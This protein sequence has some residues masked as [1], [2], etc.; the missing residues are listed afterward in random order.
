[1]AKFQTMAEKPHRSP[2]IFYPILL[3][4][5]PVLLLLANNLDQVRLNAGL[6]AGLYSLAG[7]VAL[8]LLLRLVLKDWGK[9]A[10]VSSW[11]LLLFFSY[12]HIYGLV[13]DKSLAGFIYGRHR[14][15]GPLWLALLLAGSWLLV[16]KTRLAPGLHR[17]L[18]ITILVLVLFP[19]FIIGYHEVRAWRMSNQPV[20]KA[21]AD[22]GNSGQDQA[23]QPDIYWIIL[24]GYT[25]SDVLSQVYHY[26]N[27]PF[28]DQLKGMGFVIPTCSQSNYAWTALSLSSAL[29]MNYLETYN[30]HMQA[31]D[32]RPDY[33]A[34]QGFIM[35]NPVRDKLA[36][37]GYKMIAFETD[38]PFTEVTDADIYIVGNA[39]PLE[40]MKSGFEIS[41]FEEMFMRTT[42]MRILGEAQGAFLKKVVSQV[43]TP[44][45]VH[46]DRIRFVLD[47][48]EAIPGLVPGHKFVFAH[49]VA[50]H[51]PYV[52]KPDGQYSD[53]GSPEIGYPDEIAYLDMRMIEIV[54]TILA[55]SKTPPVIIIQGDHGW[56]DKNRMANLNAYYLPNGGSQKIYPTIT[57]VNSFRIILDQYFGGNYNLL[58][59]R[60]YYSSETRQFDF[61]LVPSNCAVN[62]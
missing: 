2:I 48:L 47:Q 14:F 25:R 52:F 42:A 54:K 7:G 57:P 35:H 49:M 62:Q 28:L 31:P 44:N 20:V 33:L 17:W 26:D 32:E 1:V 40:K 16:K 8:F 11:V 45:E 53:V 41:Q 23:S 3:C 55:Q 30:P 51:A 60:S 21:A 19:V 38:F 9:A 27:T 50:P 59:D 29:H 39:N 12:G 15:L 46:Y 43:R 34:Y 24:D 13:E 18:N 10:L 37:L 4:I 61:K 58:E 6:R 36:G 56:D 5:Y 22:N